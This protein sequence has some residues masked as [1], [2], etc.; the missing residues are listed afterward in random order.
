MT[1]ASRKYCG[2]LCHLFWYQAM[3]RPS[4]L[5]CKALQKIVRLHGGG[6]ALP[7]LAAEKIDPSLLNDMLSGLPL[8]VAVISGTNG[9]TTTTR[10]VT[11]LLKS[12]GLRVFTNKTG[13]NFVRGILSALLEEAGPDGRFDYDIAVLELDEAHAV[14]FLQSAP[15]DYCLILNVCRDQLDRFCETDQTAA[16]LG[17]T[18]MA[19]KKAAVLN[20]EDPLV[21]SLP[22]RKKVFYGLGQSLRPL[23]P[24]D[25]DLLPSDHPEKKASSPETPE[26]D[27]VL[28]DL[29]GNDALYKMGDQVFPCRLMLEGAYNAFNAAGALALCRQILKDVSG[30]DLVRALSGVEEAFGRGEVLEK[31]GKK[32]RLI[33]VK[34]PAAFRQSL[35]SFG[36]KGGSVMIVIN[37]HD[38]DG[39]DVSWLWNVDFTSLS[40][41]HTVSGTRAAEMALRLKYDQVPLSYTNPD[42]GAALR[43]FMK[44]PGPRQIFATYTAMLEIRKHLTGRSLL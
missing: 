41:V 23:F 26:A 17:K 19:A 32:V 42:P 27:T 18:A 14:R 6:S 10:I 8:G 38:A 28:W 43:D 35:L 30:E 25:E 39:R 16:L 33:L 3:F 20:R 2:C 34:N 40:A 24:S 4:I 22:A 21:A 37:D 11:E 13:S 5:I 36:G 7:G 15:V 29:S 31:D 44:A 12:R 9:K 1:R